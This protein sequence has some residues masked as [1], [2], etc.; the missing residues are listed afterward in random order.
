MKLETFI[1]DGIKANM[2]DSAKDTHIFMV[3]DEEIGRI[4][5]FYERLEKVHVVVLT[6]KEN[7]LVEKSRENIAIKE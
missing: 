7:K 1:A 5:K 3:L 6:N 2:P 4:I